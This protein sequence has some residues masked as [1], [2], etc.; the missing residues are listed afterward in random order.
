ME[1]GNNMNY[2]VKKLM[3]GYVSIRDYKVDEA[4]LKNKPI[5]FRYGNSKMTLS[6]KELV[7]KRFQFVK[8]AFRSKINPEQ[9]YRLYDYKFTPAE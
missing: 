4:V 3:N 8:T 6:P 2:T 1:T 7:E 5:T 9:S